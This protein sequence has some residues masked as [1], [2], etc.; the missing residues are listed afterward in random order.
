LLKGPSNG[1]MYANEIKG[2]CYPP[3]DNYKPYEYSGKDSDGKIWYNAK[4]YRIGFLMHGNSYIGKVNILGSDVI[5]PQE[6]G[7]L[8]GGG[9]IETPGCISQYGSLGDDDGNWGCH[10]SLGIGGVVVDRDPKYNYAN[11]HEDWWVL[12]GVIDWKVE[13]DNFDGISTIDVE[14]VR[15]NDPT[16]RRLTFDNIRYAPASQVSFYMAGT[17]DGSYTHDVTLTSLVSSTTV[18]DGLNLAGKAYAVTISYSSMQNT[19]DDAYAFWQSYGDQKDIHLIDSSVYHPGIRGGTQDGND[20]WWGFG[21]C[22]SFF[23]CHS[24]TITN[25]DCIDRRCDDNDV[26]TEHNQG[27]LMT[28]YPNSWFDGNYYWDD[29]PHKICEVTAK[30]LNWYYENEDYIIVDENELLNNGRT[31][32]WISIDHDDDWGDD[33]EPLVGWDSA[34][35]GILK[36][37]TPREWS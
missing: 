11:D 13:R 29:M 15:F 31:R 18:A 26:C 3:K 25:F 30:N 36:W 2:Y 20:P 28:F 17:P 5:R 14:N 22:I 35:D 32:K 9:A 23:G 21:S 12:G 37:K 7:S 10:P 19:G 16:A 27:H 6:N 24:A 34:G 4:K 1:G 33:V 8:C